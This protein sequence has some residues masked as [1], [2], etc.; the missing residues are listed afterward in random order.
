MSLP[1]EFDRTG[2]TYYAVAPDGYTYTSEQTAQYGTR[3]YTTLAACAAAMPY[4][5]TTPF[6][7]NILGSWSSA[8]GTSTWSGPTFTATN[9]LIIRCVG[10]ARHAGVYSPTAARVSVTS[11]YGLQIYTA[12]TTVDGL[13]FVAG[14]PTADIYMVGI[15][16]SSSC[17]LDSCLIKG[18]GGTPANYMWGVEGGATGGTIKNCVIYDWTSSIGGGVGIAP[19]YSANHYNNTIRN[20][21]Y[22]FYSYASDGVATNN[23]VQ[24]C[25]TSCYYG[26][27]SFTGSNNV[28]DDST[29]PGTAKINGEGSSLDAIVTGKQIGR[30]H[31]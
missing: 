17:V 2:V 3:K 29:S 1:T 8:L 27:S 18:P 24:D 30:A 11:G 4:T 28:A 7:V 23:V 6:I 16:S 25:G 9:Y 22:G 31:V 21:D 20:C 14:T 5:P 13:Q 19:E 26:T 12:Y 10:T 15:Y